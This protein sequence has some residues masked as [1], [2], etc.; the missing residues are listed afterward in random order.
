MSKENTLD[1]IIDGVDGKQI[2]KELTEIVNSSDLDMDT[3]TNKFIA[4]LKSPYVK[5]KVKSSE[6]KL[7]YAL[8]AV[9]SLHQSSK[10]FS[11][12]PTTA[13][14][15]VMRNSSSMEKNYCNITEATRNLAKE[16]KIGISGTWLKCTSCNKI[17][18]TADPANGDNCPSCSGTNCVILAEQSAPANTIGV[19]NRTDMREGDISVF[20]TKTVGIFVYN[21]DSYEEAYIKFTGKQ[22]ELLS[23]IRFGIPFDINIDENIFVNANTNQKW[24]GTTGTS[25]ISPCSVKDFADIIDIYEMLSESLVSALSSVEDKD[26][27]ALFLSV[28]DE[29]TKPK[30]KWLI[31][32]ADPE[33]V[34]GEVGIITMY[35]DDENVA[36]QFIADDVG[37]F[38]GRYSESTRNVEGEQQ[39]VMTLNVAVESFGVPVYMIGEK[40]TKLISA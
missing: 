5:L 1:G 38:E 8:T 31:N 6:E 23:Q 33:D 19:I 4:V 16:Q 40:G 3:A 35:I 29:P 21:G 20:N 24:Y 22:K 17:F 18:D 7:S 10:A 34:S 14:S 15:V 25:K 27:C 37:I 26:Y 36:R 30:D 9:K 39:K 13:I 12:K 32:L 2:T 28:V 11:S